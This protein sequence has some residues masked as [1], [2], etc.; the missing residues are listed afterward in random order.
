LTRENAKIIPFPRGVARWGLFVRRIVEPFARR[1]SSAAGR[2]DTAL[3]RGDLARGRGDL[4]RGRGDLARGR[5][6]LARGLGN[7]ALGRANAALV[8]ANSLRRYGNYLRGQGVS[9]T[10]SNIGLFY[11]ER[12][13][14]PARRA[15]RRFSGAASE[16]LGVRTALQYSRQ[17]SLC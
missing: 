15:R 13:V 1:A 16:T 3:G 6:D 14:R 2:E 10:A 5:G 12:Q 9:V 11:S 4:A 7:S 8:G 17:I